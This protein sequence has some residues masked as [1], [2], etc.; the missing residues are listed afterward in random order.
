MPYDFEFVVEWFEEE[1]GTRP[2]REEIDRIAKS[3]VVADDLMRAA[4]EKLRDGRRHREPFVKR[5]DGDLYEARVRGKP[6]V[7]ILFLRWER[8][9]VVLHAFAK[10]SQATPRINMETA[11]RRR[12]RWTARTGGSHRR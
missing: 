1:D 5:L 12:Q 10:K 11:N 4:L 8:R 7:R 6:D 3:N 2:A 9:V